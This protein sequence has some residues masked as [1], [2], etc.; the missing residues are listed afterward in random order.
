MNRLLGDKENEQKIMNPPFAQMNHFKKCIPGTSR[1]TS[2]QNGIS[3]NCE[4]S[5]YREMNA[6]LHD[7]RQT[8]T[9]PAYAK[10][11]ALSLSRARTHT[12]TTFVHK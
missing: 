8:S 11:Q 1:K 6:Q 7:A 3:V 12:T 5:G 10:C 4:Q 9:Q 2:K